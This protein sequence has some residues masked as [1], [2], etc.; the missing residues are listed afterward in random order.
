M[1]ITFK[2]QH[3]YRETKKASSI[4]GGQFIW[5]SFIFGLWPENLFGYEDRPLLKRSHTHTKG[6]LHVLSLDTLRHVM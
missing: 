3:F 5:H 6:G 4:T 1:Q 2:P